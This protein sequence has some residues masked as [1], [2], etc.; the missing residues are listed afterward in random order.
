MSVAVII[1]A[2]GQGT[3]MRSQTP[4]ILHPLLG[5]AMV[6]YSLELAEAVSTLKPVVVVGHAASAVQA[7]VGERARFVLQEPQLGTGHAVQQAEAILKDEADTLVVLAAD[8]PLLKVETVKR[9]LELQGANPGPVTLLSAIDEDSRGFGRVVRSLDGRVRAVVEEAQATPE[10]LTLRELNASVYCFSAAWLWPALKRIPLSPKGEYYLTDAV[11]IAA[12]EGLEVRAW[13]TPDKSETIGVNTRVHL[14]EAESALRQ[15]INQAWMLEGVTLV[16]PA[17]TY[18]EPGVAIGQD[19]VI[20][21]NT[22]LQGDTQVGEGCNLGPN[23]IL[24][25]ARLGA[26]CKVF[27][28]VVQGAVLED[29]VDVGPFAHLRK[30][31]HLAQRVHMGN[32]GEVKNSY[33]GPGT[34]VGHFAYIGDATIGEGVNIGAGT[35]TCN[36]DGERKNQTEIEANVFIGSDTMLVAPVHLGEGARTGAGAVVTKNVPPY[37]L[38]VGAPARVIR[39]LERRD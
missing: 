33:L 11:G 6:A 12:A 21:P 4:K 22:H 15:R 29:D 35:V 23:T 1:L 38:A 24:Q 37:S 27:A 13:T 26:R 17:S 20:W 39:K 31:A 5:K 18:I 16:D 28:S 10:L 34:K 3:R 30:G 36:Y 8:M 7:A 2:A 25:D 9:L 14:A 19:T 32:F